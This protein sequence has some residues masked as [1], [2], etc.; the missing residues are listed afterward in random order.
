MQTLEVEVTSMTAGG[1]GLARVSGRELAIPFSIPGERVRVQ[2]RGAGRAPA[3]LVGLVRPSPHRVL[4]RCGHFGADPRAGTGSC[5]GC[6]WQHIA[7]P[8]QLRLKTAMVDRLVRE[9]V[10]DAPGARATLPSTSP[11]DPWAFRQKLHFFFDGSALARPAGAPLTMG[12]YARGSRRVVPVYECP[13]HD[14]RGN[15]IAFA[16]RDACVQAGV[17]AAARSGRGVLQGIAVRVG[18]RSQE[19]MATVVVTRDADR[20]VRNATRRLLSGATAPTAMH[21]NLHPSTADAL[22]F[23]QDTRRIAGP[24][25]MRDEVAGTTFAISPTSFFQTNIRAAEILVGLVG[26]AV[27]AGAPVLDLYA[28]AGLFALPLARSG[29]HVLA[30]EANR[31][32]VADGEASLLLNRIPRSQ[33]RFIPRPV[34][35]T[36]T[37]LPHVD[38]VVLD[39]PREGC[40]RAV[41]EHVFG[42]V[43]PAR[44]IYVSCNPVTLAR[45]LKLACG[46]G[47]AVTSIQPVDMFPHTAHIEAVVVLE[48]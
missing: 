17:I 27:P 9:A 24:A 19:S 39:P 37:G 3:R 5:G 31:D 2:A 48:R 36:L 33:C 38:A 45:D 28:G 10:P 46:R 16:L 4:P 1:D 47:Y 29:R 26:E 22:V 40:S 18:G 34:E 20:R 41:V 7:Y 35:A 11:D 43:R 6:A 25:R 30:V 14:P 15:A 13:V 8:E 21:V 32:A 23:G 44:A 12:H 42:H